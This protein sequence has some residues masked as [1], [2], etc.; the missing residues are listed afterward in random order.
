MEAHIFTICLIILHIYSF[1]L[2]NKV[3]SWTN[4]ELLLDDLVW[5]GQ[6]NRP[7][8]GRPNKYHLKIVTLQEP[9]FVIYKDPLKEGNCSQN[10]ILVRIA[11]D[12]NQ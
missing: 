3:G 7:P 6:S 9:P 12:H 10:S 2:I 4:K 5:P 11:P 1:F 8:I